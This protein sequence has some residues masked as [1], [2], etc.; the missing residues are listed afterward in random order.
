MGWEKNQNK[1]MT[2]G[3]WLLSLFFRTSD[4]REGSLAGAQWFAGKGCLVGEL[5]WVYLAL[6]RAH[7][8]GKPNY[9]QYCSFL[10]PAAEVH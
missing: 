8:K 10:D 9:R 2:A 4:D 5:R 1:M 6:T 7:Y 3:P